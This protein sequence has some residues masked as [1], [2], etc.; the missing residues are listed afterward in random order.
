MALTPSQE[1]LLPSEDDV[2]FYEQHGYYTSA[3]IY[4][5]DELDD[6][7]YGS[8]RYY[9]G[10]RDT[11]FPLRG[12][13]LDW[14]PE[15]GEGLRQND[16][17]SLQ[18]DEI[19]RLVEHPLLG[20][21]AARL[22]RETE[23]VRLFH[24]QLVYKPPGELEGTTIVGWHTDRAYWRTCT[25]DRMLTAWIPFHAV[26]AR[27][28]TLTVIDGSHRWEG[29]ERLHTFRDKDLAGLASRMFPAG[30]GVREVPMTLARGAV[31]FHHCRLIHGSYPNRGVR[32]RVAL[33]VH[34]Q[35]A[36][37][38]YIAHYDAAGNPILHINDTLCRKRADG[39]P[40]YA[41]NNICP[42]VWA[43]GA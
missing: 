4:A 17:V 10:E 6:A 16:Y 34:M 37:N 20:A 24:D 15:D 11:V 30:A 38:R 2:T 13:Y 22:C 32:P 19:R 33:A 3:R 27:S 39:D 28:G 5:D 35:D 26:D 42:V 23:S 43:R 29:A 1:A 8:E 40:D 9:A 7:V 18:N 36:A 31:S 14:R 25:S 12:G 41:D 21:I